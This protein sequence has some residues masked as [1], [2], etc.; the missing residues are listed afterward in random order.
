MWLRGSNRC[1]PILIVSTPCNCVYFCCGPT[2]RDGPTG[3]SMWLCCGL[4]KKKS[5]Q[6]RVTAHGVTF[7]TGKWCHKLC[8]RLSFQTKT[9]SKSS[10]SGHYQNCITNGTQIVD[11]VGQRYF[12]FFLIMTLAWHYL[13]KALWKR[14]CR[15]CFGLECHLFQSFTKL[16]VDFIIE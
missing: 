4:K 9:K 3:Q 7:S 2:V 15:F 11:F 14:R 12:R 6:K 10:S 16:E 5:R 8:D 1:Q 13:L